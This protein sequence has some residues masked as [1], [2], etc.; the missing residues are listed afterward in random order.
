[1]SLVLKI[2]VPVLIIGA[3]V[4]LYMAK[5]PAMTAQTNTSQETQQVQQVERP[6][7]MSDAQINADL[8]AIDGDMKTA[9]DASSE[10]DAS[11]SDTP[12]AQTE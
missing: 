2:V 12:V 6:D 3:L 8:Q 1:M 11:F 4:W 5:Y 9:A 10:V 7:P